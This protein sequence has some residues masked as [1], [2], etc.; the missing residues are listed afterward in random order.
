[1][2]QQENSLILMNQIDSVIEDVKNIKQ[3]TALLKKQLET[4]CAIL[5]TYEAITSS[6]LSAMEEIEAKTRKQ[7]TIVFA[8]DQNKFLGDAFSFYGHTIHPKLAGLSDQMFNFMTSTGPL[9]KDNV[10]VTFSYDRTVVENGESSTETVT[11]YKYEYCDLLKFETDDSKKDVF[12][13]FPANVNKIKMT[14]ELNPTNLIGN[15]ECNMIEICPYLPGTFT[16]DEIRGWTIEQ[17]LSQSLDEDPD[18]EKGPYENVGPE[19]I[20]LGGTYQLY[21]IE[22]DITIHVAENEGYPFGLRHLYFYNAR[23]DMENSYV[24]CVIKKD[25]Y[26][27]TIGESITV[28][29]PDGK[30]PYTE[31]TEYYAIYEN[32]VLQG[33]LSTNSPLARNL[34]TIYAKVPIT[35]PIKAITF[36]NI[37]TR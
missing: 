4:K 8:L 35:R 25:Q 31:T 23:M 29:E 17:Y 30:Y 34:T 7:D 24:I 37:Q 27:N 18:L 10:K 36:N 2:I 28:A 6:M 32:N 12:H 11:D 13:I 26:I 15:T 5:N 14:V 16:I 22:F 19:R 9:F 33:K 21:R 20:Y 1:M 3:N